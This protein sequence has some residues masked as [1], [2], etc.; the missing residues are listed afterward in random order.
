MNIELEN[1]SDQENRLPRLGKNIIGQYDDESIIVYQAF[2]TPIAEFAIKH[3]TFGGDSFRFRRMTW[4]KPNFLWMMYRSGWAT[5]VNQEKILAIRIKKE[6]FIEILDKAVHS[7]YKP[8]LY[9]SCELWQQ[10]LANSEVRLQWDPE[11]D[12]NG[13]KKERKAIQLGLK[14]AVLKKYC[15]DWILEIKDITDFVKEERKRIDSLG[16]DTLRVPVE[17]ILEVP[18][19]ELRLKLEITG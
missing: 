9:K 1:Y 16:I 13:E 7:S 19:K 11:H 14:G 12:P 6:G 17:R 10:E 8:E 4:I 3:Q 2:N 15:T 18:D 5:K